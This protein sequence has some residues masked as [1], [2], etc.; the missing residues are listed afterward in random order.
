MNIE[1]EPNPYPGTIPEEMWRGASRTQ[2]EWMRNH[3]RRHL[4]AREK[5]NKP[6][7]MPPEVTEY[8]IW[9]LLTRCI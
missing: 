6:V 9:R 7:S 1:E 5:F 3:E 2:R 4:E 8:V